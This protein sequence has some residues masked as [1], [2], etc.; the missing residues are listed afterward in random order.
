LV[1]YRFGDAIIPQV[2]LEWQNWLLGLSY[3]WNTS[4][5]NVATFGKGGPEIAFQWRFIK[6]PPV[7]TFKV[8]PIY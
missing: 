5:L 6:V 3:D 8:C 4:G 1:G 7:K 2:R